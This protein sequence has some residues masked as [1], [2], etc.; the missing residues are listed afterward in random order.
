MSS[1]CWGRSGR[2][3]H[4][5]AHP[6]I[7]GRLCPRAHGQF[8]DVTRGYVR[9]YVQQTEL[10]LYELCQYLAGHMPEGEDRVQAY[11]NRALP[12]WPRHADHGMAQLRGHW[13]QRVG[14]PV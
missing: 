11:L 4:R 9:P 2:D 7:G 14:R 12:D 13:V 8:Q 5:A 3:E 1:G 6:G 10:M